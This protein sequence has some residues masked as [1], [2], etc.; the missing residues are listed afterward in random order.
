[1]WLGIGANRRVEVVNSL[2]NFLSILELAHIE[3][4]DGVRVYVG[5][6]DAMVLLL[7]IDE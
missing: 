3:W 2:H 6:S 4:G 7:P 5:A 1:M